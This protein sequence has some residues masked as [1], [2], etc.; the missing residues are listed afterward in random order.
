MLSLLLSNNLSLSREIFERG[1]PTD[2]PA[3]G[4]S[5]SAEPPVSQHGPQVDACGLRTDGSVF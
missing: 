2:A 4:Y 5:P 3:S 1:H